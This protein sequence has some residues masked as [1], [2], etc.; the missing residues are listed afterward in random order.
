MYLEGSE[1]CGGEKYCLCSITYLV[2]GWVVRGSTHTYPP[3][4]LLGSMHTLA[5]VHTFKKHRFEKDCRSNLG[6]GGF[7][8][9][10][11]VLVGGRVKI[12]KLSFI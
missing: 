10:E 11:G 1:L 5:G 2:L 8:C 4:I 12:D 7:G 3:L 9:K 6:L